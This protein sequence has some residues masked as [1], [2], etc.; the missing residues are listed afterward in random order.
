MEGPPRVG[1]ALAQLYFF[2]LQR[3]LRD[4]VTPTMTRGV[5]SFLALANTPDFELVHSKDYFLPHF[6]CAS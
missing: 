5:R 6:R 1:V 3:D 4:L 2:A